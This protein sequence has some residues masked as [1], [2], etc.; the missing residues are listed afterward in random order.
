MYNIYNFYGEVS[1]QR[2]QF[3]YG[4]FLGKDRQITWLLC[5]KCNGDNW[6]IVAGHVRFIRWYVIDTIII[7]IKI[8]IKKYFRIINS[9]SKEWLYVTLISLDC[10]VILNTSFYCVFRVQADWTLTHM[11]HKDTE[12]S[13]IEASITLN[14]ITLTDSLIRWSPN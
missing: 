14:G 12:Q 2:K 3:F 13:T 5:E 1:L 7:S 6:I 8:S 9:Q 10:R 11:S 4:K